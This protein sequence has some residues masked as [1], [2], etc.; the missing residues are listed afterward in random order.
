MTRVVL[1]NRAWL[2]E[3]GVSSSLLDGYYYE[4]IE[5]Q[6]DE[7]LGIWED[8]V[9][10][11]DLVVDSK[12]RRRLGFPRGDLPKLLSHLRPPYHV[13][14]RRAVS[15]LGFDL[16]LNPKVRKDDRWP[17]QYELLQ[18]WLRVGGGV[19][20][21][22]AASGKSVIGVAAVCRTGLRTLFLF[23]QKAF[24]KQW[25][26]EFYKHTNLAELEEFSGESLAGWFKGRRL[27]PI[28]FCTFQKLQSQRTRQF[29]WDH[30]D[31]FGMVICDETHHVAARTNR[32][33]VLLFNPLILGGVTATP[34]RKDK[35]E[36]IYFDVLGPIVASGGSEQ[37]NPLMRL[38][39]TGFEVQTNPY[40]P[41]FAQFGGFLNQ[42]VKDKRRNDTIIRKV[43]MNLL[44]EQRCVLIVSE[45]V[46]HCHK[47]RDMLSKH[48]NRDRI[49]VTTGDTPER[50]KIYKLVDKG[51]FNVL[52]ASKV[53]DEGVNVNRLDTLHLATPTASRNRA[54]QRLGRIRRPFPGKRRPLGY[55]YI[56]E[57]HGSIFG[58]A[59]ARQIV[60]SEIG[61]MVVD[62]R[63]GLVVKVRQKRKGGRRGRRR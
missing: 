27:F 18:R 38:V 40:K 63:T 7:D 62:D 5:H 54:E 52:I 31:Y 28:T 39:Y 10:G 8:V 21:A 42:M 2:P 20:K 17:E 47:L 61:A 60:Y 15:P 11:I 32:N 44:E 55:D 19:I 41:D 26:E 53:I 50:N 37:L 23:D 36:G 30:R 4:K 51:K 43:G 1:A 9:V 33:A 57:G 58:A 25:L 6:R 49:V 13:I 29:M 3:H 45:R 16:L 35:L 34:H 56:D 46:R 14:D 24:L 59:R 22:P 12:N 48:Y